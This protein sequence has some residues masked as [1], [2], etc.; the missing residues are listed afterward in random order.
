[1]GMKA[2][3]IKNKINYPLEEIVSCTSLTMEATII[4]ELTHP[5]NLEDLDFDVILFL[6]RLSD[7]LEIEI[8]QNI[9]TKNIPL[10]LITFAENKE[11]SSEITDHYLFTE[12][13]T[14]PLLEKS[15]ELVIQEKK[16]INLNKKIEDYQHFLRKSKDIFSRDMNQI[17]QKE[18]EFFHE[19]NNTKSELKWLEILL[20]AI[21]CGIVIFDCRR[22]DEIIM[23]TEALL[24]MNCSN[25]E[26]VHQQSLIYAKD[27]NFFNFYTVDGEKITT[28]ELPFFK[29]INGAEIKDLELIV[30]N[31][32]KGDISVLINSS[33]VYDKSGNLIASITAISDMSKLKNIEED[34]INTIHVKNIIIEESNNRI[35]N[36]LQT[37]TSLLYLNQEFDHN[38]PYTEINKDSRVRMNLIRQI[39]EKLS[40]YD[41]DKYVDFK[42][43]AVNVCSEL[44]QIYNLEH[45]VNLLVEG[46]A[47]MTL[48]LVLPAGLII[49]EIVSYRLRSFIE[50]HE[51]KFIEED[52]FNLRIKLKGYKG[53]ITI[54]IID[55]GPEVE[56]NVPTNKNLK[57]TNLLLEQ[58][59]G[60]IWI[61]SN[62]T[63]TSFLIEIIYFDI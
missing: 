15:I 62:N 58:L 50:D 44:L 7:P 23:N 39:N 34:L 25:L 33:P 42:E 53:K 2:L 20:N 9:S 49:D 21:P 37:I 5:L 13:L 12:Q 60:L 55:N 18:N 11:K 43:Y 63:Q 3:I 31:D 61:Q 10:I 59:S 36:N 17:I 26:Q 19:Y 16:I 22:C 38:D 52:E 4:D 30:R 51:F 56:T 40:N 14:I 6:S 48:D 47:I 45:Q 54:Q 41:D 27:T 24:I 1:M 8:F 32:E 28:D 57:L 46:S 35:L 29:T